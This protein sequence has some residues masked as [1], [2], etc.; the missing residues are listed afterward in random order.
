MSNAI[1][2]NAALASGLLIAGAAY[3]TRAVSPVGAMGLTQ[4][5]PGSAREFGVS[6]GF[7]NEQN[8]RA[9]QRYLAIQI[10]RFNDIRL[11]LV[12]YS[13]GPCRAARLGRVPDIH[14]TQGYVRDGIDCC[15]AL[16]AG[17][18]IRNRSQYSPSRGR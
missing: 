4:L 6:N 8:L 9:G 7:D 1:F 5:T 11:A 13:S 17:L 16:T 12:A 10:R 14:E 18:G 2:L 3:N 15:V